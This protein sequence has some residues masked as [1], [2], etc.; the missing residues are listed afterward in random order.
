MS[1]GRASSPRSTR[2]SR[3]GRLETMAEHRTASP[4]LSGM[5]NT[6]REAL[7]ARL[8]R[9]LGEEPSLREVRMFGS[10]S[11]MVDERMIVAAGR[12]GHLLV[13]VDPERSEELLLRA[14]ARRAEMG[15]GKS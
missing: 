10:L 12:N 8:R 4:E 5:T 15:K 2:P 6:A 14:G 1:S 11:F 3:P 7:A 9:L 13:H